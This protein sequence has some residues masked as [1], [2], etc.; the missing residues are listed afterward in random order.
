MLIQ[1]GIA[2]LDDLV[3]GLI[4][5]RSYLLSGN[6]GAGK[7]VSC[8]E[9]LDVALERGEFAALLTHDD[10]TD[11]LS[12]AAFL[13]I[14]L[15]RA[16]VEERF[17]LIRYRPTFVKL[18]VRAP[19]MDE[20]FA[21]LTRAIGP[22]KPIRLAIDSIV[23]VLECGR[24]SGAASIFALIHVLDDLGATA[25]LTY[26]GDLAGLYNPRLEPL[27][28]RAAGVFHLA[29]RS[30][31]RRDGALE[32][33]KLRY[34]A[35]SLGP[36][37]FRIQAGA[38]FVPVHEPGE[39]PSPDVQRKLLVLNL[40]DPFPGD[41][42]QMLERDHTVVV[43]TGV[44]GATSDL[45]RGEAGALLITVRRDVMRDALQ[46]VRELR[47]SG[48][49]IP[50]VVVTP[51][52]VRSSDRTRALR[53]GA[54]DF[55][56]TNLQPEEFVAR[57]ESI[58]QRGH[59]ESVPDS[60]PEPPAILQPTADGES[61]LLLDGAQFR[62]AVGLHVT[63]ERAPFFTVARAE[64]GNGDVMALADLAL[65]MSRLASGD[66]VGF[67]GRS[68]LLYLD[69]ARPKDLKAYL[70][71][72]HDEW[73]GAAADDIAV[74]TFGYPAEEEWMRTFVRGEPA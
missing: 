17:A 20:V 42:L 14:D 46:L 19:N 56:S 21:E 50:I 24:N 29:T 5:G 44:S 41:L 18:A 34:E 23:P 59:S 39:P 27:V 67:D 33:R 45:V 32:I 71:R 48:S 70:G 49:T 15:H 64:P 63:G 11:V 3:G 54:D 62:R 55:L 22:K 68:V 1:S 35:R 47:R 37:A 38:G 36:A 31:G 8:L 9:F 30:H 65:R 12:S 28:Q 13:G 60:E 40:A 58:A 74:E 52:L 7:S 2:P 51:Y 53:A 25:L 16:L 43:R 4:P 72:L 69:A 6:A 61:Y 26:P 66:L 73:R 10:P 57:V